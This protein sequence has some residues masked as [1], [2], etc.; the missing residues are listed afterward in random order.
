M[1]FWFGRPLVPFLKA[2]NIEASIEQADQLISSLNASDSL[3]DKLAAAALAHSGE[4]VAFD[5]DYYKIG[6][7]GGDIPSNKGMAADVLVRCYRK[8]G[9]DLQVLVHED[10]AENF[11]VYPQLWD[12]TGP[13][14]NIDHR[15]VPNLQRFLERKGETLEPS[16][17]AADYKAGD[18]VIWTLANAET[19]IGIVVPGPGDRANE[20][21]VVHNMGS[22]V[23]WENVLFDYP[24]QR[25]F[26][27]PAPDA[28]K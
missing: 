23:K 22:G 18:I 11:R 6:Y 10:M 28:A 8:L 9:L 4:G 21:W 5:R 25:H 24:L 17:S 16:R 26:R 7:P 27:F 20:A 15:R 1:G 13:D 14:A 2:S 3:G 19:H 12:A